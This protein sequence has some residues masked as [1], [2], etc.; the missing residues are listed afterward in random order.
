MAELIH[1]HKLIQAQQHVTEFC[2]G[3]LIRILC[4]CRERCLLLLHKFRHAGQ[5]SVSACVGT[6]VMLREP[7][8]CVGSGAS[9]MVM[10]GS[11]SLRLTLR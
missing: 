9:N 7:M 1:I 5:F 11:S 6:V 2:E 10:I 4:V 8:L 3:D